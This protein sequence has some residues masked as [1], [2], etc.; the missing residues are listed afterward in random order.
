MYLCRMDNYFSA[1]VSEAKK[2]LLSWGH[3]FDVFALLDSNGL[4]QNP[5]P[6]EFSH[7]QLILAADAEDEINV[8]KA[9]FD[10][11][12]QFVA[13]QFAFGY[14]GYDLKNYVEKLASSNHDGLGFPDMHFFIPRHIVAIDNDGRFCVL[15]SD[16]DHSLLLNEIM[17]SQHVPNAQKRVTVTSRIS[18][19]EYI[20]SVNQIKRH[21][22]R[23]DIYEMNFCQEFYATDAEIDPIATYLELSALSPTPFAC[24]YKLHDKFLI[25]ASPERF[26]LKQGCKIISQPIK[27]TIRRG[28]SPEED[29]LL[30]TELRNNR[31]E[32][33]ENVMIVDLVRNDLSRTA[34]DGSVV[35]TELFGIYPFRQVFQMISTVESEVR[36][37]ISGVEVIKHAFPMGSM[38]GAPKVK[39][40]EL[41]EALE[42]TKRGLYSGAVGYFTPSG[43]FDFNVVI[44]S[45]LYNQS[46]R[47]L[48]FSVG[49]AITTG[50][51]P[52]AEY[53][54][55]LVKAK[56]IMEVLGK[57]GRQQN[58]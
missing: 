27:G 44:R 21:I 17:Q 46:N 3:R 51:N 32:Q 28:N 52:E 56:A 13:N 40:M 35:V 4:S 45:I 19:D 47:Y 25:S 9:P 15:K 41:I 33:S 57:K 5:I 31:K 42:S 22:L 20:H 29:E 12:Q 24:C 2:R 49:S 30:K 36:E 39:A 1:N 55:C 37:G 38:T 23:G 10:D 34:K 8:S 6:T 18:R 53:D 54:E 58:N 43:N 48:S 7:Y 16:R 26:M 11:L 50:S 14:L